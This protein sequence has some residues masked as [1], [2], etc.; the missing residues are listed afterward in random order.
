MQKDIRKLFPVIEYINDIIAIIISVFAVVAGGLIYILFRP[1]EPV[2]FQWFNIV[3]LE[4]WF[5]FIRNNTIN[6][7]G[8]LPEWFVFSLPNGLWAFA[9][10]LL[11]FTFW[12]KSDS[13]L[14]FFWYLSVPVLVLGFEFLQY[15]GLIP[16]TFSVQDVLLGIFGIIAGYFIGELLIKSNNNEKN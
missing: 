13:K 16:G 3:N 8:W 7:R 2:F 12:L 9:Y 1:S 10:S 4:N 6:L 5:D 14:K 15:F 11:I